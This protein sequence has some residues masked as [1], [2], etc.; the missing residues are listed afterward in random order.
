MLEGLQI[1]LRTK[2][3]PLNALKLKLRRGQKI[4]GFWGLTPKPEVVFAI[5]LVRFCRCLPDVVHGEEKKSLSCIVTRKL[6]GGKNFNIAI[7][8]GYVT[9][10]LPK[11][12]ETL[13]ALKFDLR[14]KFGPLSAL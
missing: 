4:F 7:L 2:F 12:G 11:L 1:D 3:A 8:G 13:E 9:S 10:T 14:T 5:F 6:K